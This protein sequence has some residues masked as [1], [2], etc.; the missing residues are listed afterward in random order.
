MIFSEE[1]KS[2]I[3]LSVRVYVLCCAEPL[4]SCPTLYSLINCSPSGSS[5]H[6]ICQARISVWVSISF[7]SMCA[8]VSVTV[9]ESNKCILSLRGELSARK[10]YIFCLDPTRLQN[11]LLI[12]LLSKGL[13]IYIIKICK[14]KMKILASNYRVVISTHYLPALPS[15]DFLTSLPSLCPCLPFFSLP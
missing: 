2:F 5:V 13:T 10:P 14:L 9:W 1:N 8:Y 15:H 11:R 12:A 7:S 4:Q 6:G 3:L